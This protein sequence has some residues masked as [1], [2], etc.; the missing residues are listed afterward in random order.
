MKK[1]INIYKESYS[2]LSKESWMLAIVMLLN[3]TGSM[4]LP[5]LGIYLTSQL[6]FTLEQSGIVLSCFGIGSL[7]GS[8]LGGYLTDKLGNFIVQALS[9]FLSAPLFAILPYF[10]TLESASLLMLVLSTITSLF[11]PANSVA[12]TRYAKKENITR[13][14]SLNRMAVNLGF[15]FGP[16]LGGFLSNYSYD[17]L[18]YGNAIAA[19]VAAIVFVAFF[20]NRKERNSEKDLIEDAEITSN[21]PKKERNPYTDTQFLIFTLFCATFSISMFQILNTLPLYYKEVAQLSQTEIGFLMASSGFSV[22]LFEMLLVH[23]AEKKFTITQILFYGSLITGASFLIFGFT[24]ALIML[25]VAIFLMSIGEMLVLP[26]L[27]TVTALRAGVK[28]KGAYMGLNGLSLAIAFIVSPYL[29]TKIATEYSFEYLWFGTA[30]L[31]VLT[32]YGFKMNLKKLI[33][34]K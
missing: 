15:S 9:L 6:N 2:G 24:H 30:I 11:L 32:A 31:L 26:F 20:Y 22:F 5:F 12:I 34:D 7:V 33:I 25:F 4:V 27:S 21:T 1:L 14:F 10:N 19:F 29:G 13:A 18:F 28:N 16:A 23:W 3:R 8:F 17:L